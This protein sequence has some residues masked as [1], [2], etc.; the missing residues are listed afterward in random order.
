MRKNLL[1]SVVFV[2]L[3]TFSIAQLTGTKAIPG[4]Y[5]SVAAAINAL[6]TSG[7]GAGGVTFN[8]AGGYTETI[9][10]PLSITATGTVA[11]PIVFQKSGAG[12]NP[13]ITAYVGTATPGSAIQDG[14]WNL[15]GSDYVTV[16]GI[17]LLDPNS[18][19]PATMEYGY[20]LYKAGVT[21][22]CQYNTIKNC[23]VTLNRVNNASGTAPAVDGS[24]AINVM[25]A[26]VATQ[27]TVAVPTAA[28]GTNSYN[29]FYGNTLQNCNIGIALI[30]Y[31]GASPFTLCDF[32]NDIGGTSL[33]TGNN[34][35]NYGGAAA[36]TN[37][38]AGVRTLAQYNLNVSYNT[39]NNNN[40][41][42]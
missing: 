30:G 36:A 3:S 24:R 5:A 37:P 34:I 39:V 14:I 41:S 25:N 28:S 38:A 10:A 32:G 2:F 1:L 29:V 22:G 18:T 21:D 23:V 4:D 13:L 33:A 31:A 16:N 7:V 11:N 40:G 35:L 6:N 9:L 27:T 42:G 8:I 26:L 15:V 17:D 19:N 12:S 20:G